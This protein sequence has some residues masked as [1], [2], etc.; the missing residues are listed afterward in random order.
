MQFRLVIDSDNEAFSEDA[1]AEVARILRE[2]AKKIENC[3]D[4][5]Q[6]RDVNGN[7]VGF[8]SLTIADPELEAAGLDPDDD[9]FQ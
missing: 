6:L 8:A 9:C 7:K 3:E 1:H 2:A 4:E 5:I